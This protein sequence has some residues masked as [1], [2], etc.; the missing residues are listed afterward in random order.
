[1]KIFFTG[2]QG[3]L[4]V[5][6]PVYTEG[7]FGTVST[8]ENFDTASLANSL[9][10]AT[11]LQGVQSFVDKRELRVDRQK[12]TEGVLKIGATFNQQVIAATKQ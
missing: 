8:V 7:E 2:E 5:K 12:F 1:M 11:G 6:A 10:R 4:I 9:T 3:S